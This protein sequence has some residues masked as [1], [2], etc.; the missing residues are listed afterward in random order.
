M[1]SLSLLS[2]SAVDIVIPSQL[3]RQQRLRIDWAG[4]KN[5]DFLGGQDS[6]LPMQGA[7]V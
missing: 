7:W 1:G 3:P 2:M 6:V 4:L 5:R